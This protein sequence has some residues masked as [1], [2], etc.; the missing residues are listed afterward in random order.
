MKKPLYLILPALIALCGCTEKMFPTRGVKASG[1]VPVVSAEQPAPVVP[2]EQDVT[3]LAEQEP[4]VMMVERDPIPEEWTTIVDD[5]LVVLESMSGELDSLLDG[6]YAQT[7]LMVDTT[8]TASATNP[9][10]SDTVYTD[11]LALCIA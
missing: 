10:F 4:E 6:W 11:R 2:V 1:A 8:C 7:Y 9:T 5:S 3:A